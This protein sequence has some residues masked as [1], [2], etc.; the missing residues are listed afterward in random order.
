MAIKTHIGVGGV[1]EEVEEIYL[2]KGGVWEE[3]TAAHVGIAGNVW[4][5]MFQK[6]TVTLSGATISHSRDVSNPGL[7]H[8][9]LQVNNPLY[10]MTKEEGEGNFTSLSP[11]TNWI[12]PTS[13]APPPA[14]EYE[15]RVTGVTGTFTESPGADGTWFS[16]DV[17]REW[18]VQRHTSLGVGS[19]TTS[20]TLEIRKIGS[21]VPSTMSSS[22]Y[23]LTATV[24]DA[25]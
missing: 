24:V 13:P 23:S 19:K 16:L 11:T 10:S 12:R 8:A 22:A 21:T 20:F 14:S 4:R 18:I 7:A 15:V 5:Q 9:G 3:L 6:Y 25:A 2:G 17:L 1:D